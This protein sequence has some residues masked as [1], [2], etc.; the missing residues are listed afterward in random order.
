[1]P[2]IKFSKAAI[3]RLKLG[4]KQIYYYDTETPGWGLCV[5]QT[6]KTWIV[7][8]GLN[9]RS[10]RMTLG[11]FPMMGIDQARNLASEALLQ[12]RRGF[13]PRQEKKTAQKRVV[14]LKDAFDDYIKKK[15]LKPK[16]LRGIETI[17]K[18]Y[19]SDWEN[20]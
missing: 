13:D 20:K 8:S 6:K 10:T 14:T 16:T 9:G 19:L 12:M 7:H 15:T 18:L 4:S 3:E 1:M 5:G 2:R 11:I 17:R